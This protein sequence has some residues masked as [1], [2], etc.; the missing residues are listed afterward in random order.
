MHLSK[1]VLSFFT[2]SVGAVTALRRGTVTNSM[3]SM[4]RGGAGPIDAEMAAKVCVLILTL[5]TFGFSPP[6]CV[7]FILFIYIFL[8]IELIPSFR[9]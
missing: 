4:P 5:D 9:C 6:V 3:L 7:V 2:I 1:I 8:L